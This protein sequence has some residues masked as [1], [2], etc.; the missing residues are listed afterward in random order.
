MTLVGIS[1]KNILF[2]PFNTL[3][4]IILFALGIGLISFLL[5]IEKQIQDKFEK[6]QAGIQLVVGAKGSPLQLI[7]CSM[8]HIDAPTGNI[9]LKDAAPFLNPKHPIIAKAVPLSLGDSYNGHRI[10]GTNTDFPNL[11]N[12]KIAQGRWCD[13][14]MEVVLG[15]NVAKNYQLGID[16][17]FRSSHGLINDSLAEKHDHSFVV[18]GIFAPT[19]SVLDELIV[20]PLES[21]WAVHEHEEDHAEN[22]AE[23]HTESEEKSSVTDTR[24]ITSLLIKFRGNNIQ[25][26][27]F[28]RN[29]NENTNMQAANPA[30]E[31]NRL[32]LLMG[33]GMDAIQWLGWIIMVVSGF[34]VFV[35]LLQALSDRKKEMAMLRIMGAAPFQ[36]FSLILIEGVILATLSCLVGILLAHSSI[37]MLSDHLKSIYNYD[38]NAFLFILEE[39]WLILGALFIGILTAIYPSIKAY[40][41][42]MHQTLAEG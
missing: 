16:S 29:I 3:L 20:T 5:L 23:S 8:Y 32:Y 42:N 27:N 9:L 7:L 19:G 21:I 37:W 41:T 15:A 17:K 14:S 30:L 13:S 36:L 40:N 11:Y 18:K 25:S 10:V 39:F 12:G 26:L 22:H 31:I 35:A 1:W 24:A 6:N 28:L 2:R 4:I 38:F 33:S 34:S